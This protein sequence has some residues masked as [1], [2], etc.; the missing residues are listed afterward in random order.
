[1]P[2]SMVLNRTL[3]EQLLQRYTAATGWRTRAIRRKLCDSA[4]YTSGKD[5][6]SVEENKISNEAIYMFPLAF[7]E[8]KT[9]V[10]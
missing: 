3:H 5:I 1:M 8:N 4:G 6:L 9:V 2:G 7:R 10:N